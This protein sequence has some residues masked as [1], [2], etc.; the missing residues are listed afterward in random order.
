MRY[1]AFALDEEGRRQPFLDTDLVF[2]DDLESLRKDCRDAVARDPDLKVV[3]LD[4]TFAGV[5]VVTGLRRE[6]GES[7]DWSRVKDPCKRTSPDTDPD[8]DPEMPF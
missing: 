3:V 4:E 6:Q 8:T 7:M 5:E 1:Y 2:R